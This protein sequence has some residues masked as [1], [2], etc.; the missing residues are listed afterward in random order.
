MGS[1]VNVQ[2]WSQCYLQI[3]ERRGEEETLGGCFGQTK[4]R[5][6]LGEHVN[7]VRPCWLLCCTA[8][9]NDHW[10]QF[11]IFRWF[12]T[13]F[14]PQLGQTFYSTLSQKTMEH[15]FLYFSLF[16]DRIWPLSCDICAFLEYSTASIVLFQDFMEQCHS[17]VGCRGHD[18]CL[19]GSGGGGGEGGFWLL[20]RVSLVFVVNNS[21]P[22]FTA[23]AVLI[24]S[25][26]CWAV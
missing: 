22:S 19:C 23:A 15:F 5:Q 24:M 16:I 10:R 4:P 6:A 12:F 8:L 9:N 14:F 3:E 26:V 1:E 13:T 18:P 25:C 20:G 21:V 11:Y 17:C 2:L 7:P